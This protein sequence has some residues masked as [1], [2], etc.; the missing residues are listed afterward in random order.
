MSTTIMFIHGAWV[1]PSCWKHFT[2]LFEAKGVTC[3]APAWPYL[4]DVASD[5]SKH[6]DPNFA[7]LTIKMLVDHYASIIQALPTPPVLIGHSFGGLIVQLLI[8]R[9]LGR[10]GVAIDSAPPRGVFPSFRALRSALPIILSWKGWS[11]LHKMSFRTF[12]ET[13]AN[14]L[15]PDELEVAYK[16]NIVQAPGLIYFQAALGIGNSVNFANPERKPLLLIAAEDDRVTTPSMVD[17]MYKL[18][19]KSP[20]LVE[21]LQFMG[22]SHWLIA[23]SDW[24]DVARTIQM[25][26]RI[27]IK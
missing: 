17:A 10:C 1:T 20:V 12:A 25:W 15:P 4:D 18:H 3:I 24:K 5:T 21:K 2:S 19:L 13:F 9:G 6:V 7:K 8:D 22:R 26:L 11:K 16:S 23:D 14:S 27:N